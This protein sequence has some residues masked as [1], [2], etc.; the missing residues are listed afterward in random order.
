MID[1]HM[2]LRASYFTAFRNGERLLFGVSNSPTFLQYV[3]LN[4]LQDG[5]G[6]IAI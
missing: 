2:I 4:L 1:Y 6:V 3:L 5:V